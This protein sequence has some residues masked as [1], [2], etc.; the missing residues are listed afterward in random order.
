MILRYNRNQ[1]FLC[2]GH[3]ALSALGFLL[4]CFLIYTL[5]VWVL[6][7]IAFTNPEKVTLFQSHQSPLVFGASLLSVI[8]SF[9]FAIPSWKRSKTVNPGILNTVPT[10]LR[11]QSPSTLRVYGDHGNERGSEFSPVGLSFGWIRARCF[12]MGIGKLYLF[13]PLQLLYA[14]DRIRNLIPMSS[15]LE[16]RIRS[17]CRFAKNQRTWHTVELYDNDRHCLE[18]LIRMELL[19]YSCTKEMVKFRAHL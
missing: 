9:C 6:G 4:G 7:V 10:S 14:C 11:L 8:I 17:A 15:E 1:L 16:L 12:F 19:D 13:G 3:L 18:L 5:V 2:S